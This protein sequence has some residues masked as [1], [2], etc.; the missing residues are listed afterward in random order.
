MN[1]ISGKIKK[2]DP[3]DQSDRLNPI[4]GG[5]GDANRSDPKK[6]AKG[7]D[8]INWGRKKDSQKAHAWLAKRNP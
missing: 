3:F 6:F 1:I 5:K 4:G 7:Y 2:R 8:S